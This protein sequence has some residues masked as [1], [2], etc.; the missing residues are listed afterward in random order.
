MKNSLN[1]ES[2]GCK[3][4][5]VRLARWFARRRRAIAD[6]LLRGACYGFGTGAVGLGF[7]WIERWIEHH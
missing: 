3:R 4:R 1:P 6:Q 7:W 2:S 5:I